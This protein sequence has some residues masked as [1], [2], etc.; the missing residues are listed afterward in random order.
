MPHDGVVVG[1]VE[2]G[3]SGRSSVAK[4]NLRKI[5]PWSAL[6]PWQQSLTKPA[7]SVP[8]ATPVTVTYDPAFHLS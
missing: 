4:P 2:F 3:A 8:H 5:P 6:A 1:G 7:V